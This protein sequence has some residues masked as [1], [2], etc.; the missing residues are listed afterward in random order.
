[1]FDYILTGPISGVSAGQYITGLLDELLGVA[2]KHTLLPASMIANGHV[3]QLPV[4]FT[5][6]MFAVFVTIYYWWQKP[7]GHRGV[8][9]KSP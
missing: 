9:R 5:S 2:A 1:M 7:E 8:E 3:P 4:D 6:A